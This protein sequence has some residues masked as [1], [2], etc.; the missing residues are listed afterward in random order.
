MS[1]FNVSSEPIVVTPSIITEKGEITLPS[2]S[3]GVHETRKLSIGE[4]LRQQGIEAEKGTI[5]LR[6]TGPAH[7][8]APA[9]FVAN[10]ATGFSLLSSFNARRERVEAGQALW[11]FPDVFLAADPGLGFADQ[12][13]TAYA[14]VSNPSKAAASPQLT[15]FVGNAGKSQSVTLPVKPLRPLETRVIDLSRFVE[16]GLLPRSA[17]YISLAVTHQ[18]VPGDVGLTVFSVGKN[19]DFVSPAEGLVKSGQVIDSTYW[20]IAGDFQSDRKSVV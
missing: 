16:S 9:L 10:S 12:K 2:L 6:Y 11:R 7:A 20:D 15:A 17:S 18:G 4:I 8:L 5:S 13:L 14:I 3:L 19:K 1:L